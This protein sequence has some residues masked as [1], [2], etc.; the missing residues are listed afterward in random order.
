MAKMYNYL[1][2]P[3]MV[4]HLFQPNNFQIFDDMSALS[5]VQL[6]C[7]MDIIAEIFII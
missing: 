3:V 7:R 5:P 1:F 2:F 4:N 6:S